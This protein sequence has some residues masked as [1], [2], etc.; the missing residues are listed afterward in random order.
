[1]HNVHW[2]RVQRGMPARTSNIP[3]IWRESKICR[4]KKKRRKKLAICAKCAPNK[5]I[6]L[7]SN[8]RVDWDLFPLTQV[9]IAIFVG[10]IDIDIYY[11]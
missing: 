1:M 2:E 11:E 4:P 8:N 7:A 6:Y 5:S 10:S 9:V 3:L